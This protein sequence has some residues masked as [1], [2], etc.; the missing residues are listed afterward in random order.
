M[1]IRWLSGFETQRLESGAEESGA[2]QMQT[3]VMGSPV[4][5]DTPERTPLETLAPTT[6]MVD[7]IAMVTGTGIISDQG[8][9]G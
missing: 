1:K 2:I 7:K 8:G 9:S 3:T 6:T 4:N 5:T